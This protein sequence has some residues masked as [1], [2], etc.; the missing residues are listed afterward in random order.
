MDHFI[1]T[2]ILAGILQ[3]IPATLGV[4]KLMRFIPRMVMVGF[5][6]ALAIIFLGDPA[7]DRRPDARLPAGRPGPRAILVFLPR[8][9]TM[10]PAPLVTMIAITAVVWITGWDLPHVADQ[11]E[12]PR[13]LPELFIP[14]APLT[15]ET[16]RVIGPVALGMALVGLL[17]SL[18]TAKLVDGITAPTPKGPARA[19]AKASPTSCPAS[20]AAW[21][22]TR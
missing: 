1:A 4:G 15:V 5:V 9:T 12:L 8:G 10:V 18:M 13:S 20:S 7:P 2:V 6:N 19:G 21:A 22:A 14:Q 3:I 16:L 11:D 17:E